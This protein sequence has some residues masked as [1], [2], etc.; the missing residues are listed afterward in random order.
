MNDSNFVIFSGDRRAAGDT[1]AD[2]DADA[3]HD[4]G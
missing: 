1:A 2:G 3:R 4:Q